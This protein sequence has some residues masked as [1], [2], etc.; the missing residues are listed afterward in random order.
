MGWRDPRPPA[1]VSR[2]R[3]QVG[4]TLNPAGP[5]ATLVGPDRGAGLKGAGRSTVPRRRLRERS[6]RN[7]ARACSRVTSTAGRERSDRP[8]SMVRETP[9][10]S[11]V[12]TRERSSLERQRVAGRRAPGGFLGGVG[13]GSEVVSRAA[14][15]FRDG[16]GA[17]SE[18]VSRAPG[19]FRGGCGA[20]SGSSSESIRGLSGWC[21]DR[22]R[23]RN[24]S[25]R[26]R[27]E[28]SRSSGHQHRTESDQ[29]APTGRRRGNP[30]RKFLPTAE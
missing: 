30:R 18:V 29:L 11:L 6:E 23:L 12:I 25:V 16:I 13:A 14:E 15:G 2:R 21:R 20:V 8:R 10:A 17:G 22:F 19:G 27:P 24:E 4:G 9:S 1:E 26:K 7:S 3:S 28:P 5:P